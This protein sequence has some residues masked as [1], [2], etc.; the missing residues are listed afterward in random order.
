[1]ADSDQA[2]VVNPLANDTHEETGPF[3]DLACMQGWPGG[4]A[5]AR[6]RPGSS[7]GGIAGLHGFLKREGPDSPIP[8]EATTSC[9]SCMF[10]P[11]LTP[12]SPGQPTPLARATRALRPPAATPAVRPE[13]GPRRRLLARLRRAG[14]PRSAG[15]GRRVRTRAQA[16]SAWPRGGRRLDG[17]AGQVSR[18][19]LPGCFAW[20]ASED[21]CWSV[22]FP[23]EHSARTSGGTRSSSMGYPSRGRSAPSRQ[24]LPIAPPCTAGMPSACFLISSSARP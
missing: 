4:T 14:R 24:R 3:K 13:G 12:R 23:T 22:W 2:S 15:P 10:F 7:S 5:A 1:M 17:D 11:W 9:H 6:A 21:D 8:S 19:S 20:P 16:A 18:R